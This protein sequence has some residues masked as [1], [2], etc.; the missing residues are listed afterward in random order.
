[1]PDGLKQWIGIGVGGLVFWNIWPLWA[2]FIY[3]HIPPGRYPVVLLMALSI[4]PPLLVGILVWFVAYELLA[5]I[6]RDA[7]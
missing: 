3:P 7:K 4:V 5:R 1:M 6:T 2:N